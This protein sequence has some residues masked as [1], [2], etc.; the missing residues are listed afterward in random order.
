M[1]G[2]LGHYNLTESAES[3]IK[4]IQEMISTI[5]HRGPDAN[6]YWINEEKNFS[7]G[8][9][10]LSILD[11]SKNGSQPMSSHGNNLIISF[12]GEI[13]NF[14]KLKKELEILGVK[15]QSTSDT[16]VLLSAFET[17]GVDFA[18]TKIE[19]MF[20]IALWD[21]KNKK[22]FLIRDRMGEKPLFYGFQD[23]L[24]FFSS[25]LRV[26]SKIKKFKK[27][28]S[29]KSINTFLHFG[30]LDKDQ[31]F[32]ED[33]YSLPKANYLVVNLL[34][35]KVLSK[36]DFFYKKYWDINDNTNFK[37]G[38]L[39]D[40]ECQLEQLLS[41]KVK[42]QIISDVP[43][44]AF[45]SGGVDSSLIVALMQEQSANNV[46]TFSIG[47]EEN[48]FDEAPFAKKIANY[49]GTEHQE[50]YISENDLM[51]TATNIVNTYDQPFG[52]ISSIPTKLLSDFV[53]KNVTVSLSGDGGDEL[54]F[55]YNRYKVYD[56]FYNFKFR[57][58]LAK[59]IKLL[60]NNTIEKV[61]S[62]IDTFSFQYVTAARI[63]K[64]QKMIS[65]KK[66]S[67]INYQILLMND[68][69]LINRLINYPINIED[70]M[71]LN[72][73]YDLSKIKNK[74]SAHLM[75]ILNEDLNH[76]LPE[77]ILVKVDR[78]AMSSSL[79][80]RM[81]FLN[82]K[83]VEF[84]NNLPFHYKYNSNKD[85]KII[86]KNILYKKIPKELLTRPKQGFS[87]P[88]SSWLRGTLKDWMY[89]NLSRE[90]LNKT[91]VFNSIEIN[92]IIDQFINKNESTNTQLIWNILML[93]QW[94]HTN[95][96][97]L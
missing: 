61:F 41:E 88:I 35:K 29:R 87:V 18:L 43:I 8:H 85:M 49:I 51:D 58:L 3:N 68:Q 48:G 15:F 72:N 92:K 44:G 64:F 22:L 5:N 62:K 46:K 26:L 90:G 24:F 47:F 80:T 95:G 45:L 94:M 6:G 40:C 60:P 36:E 30:Y 7:I 83:V 86:I 25:E 84:A 74:K 55:G 69:D 21:K 19:G 1:C 59:T 89:D 81:P 76:Y 78:A 10:R 65:K 4:T 56:K 82:H 50:L 32:F 67:K 38:S 39:E 91:N 33:V 34:N 20:A 79:E 23:D 16:E 66:K 28:V 53:K 77:D 63:N 9:V 14:K 13:Y 54:F 97:S 70:Y 75:N 12:N 11:L 27:N 42:D 17:W 37:Y 73:E 31:T 2:I 52:D 93:Q 57:N 71:E 96:L